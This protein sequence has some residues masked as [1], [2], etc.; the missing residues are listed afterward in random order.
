MLLTEFLGN[1]VPTT[2]ELITL[3]L[4]SV[5]T[6][7]R[8]VRRGQPRFQQALARLPHHSRAVCHV[9]SRALDHTSPVPGTLFSFRAARLVT[10]L[11]VRPDAFPHAIS[12]QHAHLGSPG[13]NI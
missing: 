5:A 3:D 12:V 2:P 8:S 13:A 1:D 4:F 6:I 11:G 10:L 9:P 7:L